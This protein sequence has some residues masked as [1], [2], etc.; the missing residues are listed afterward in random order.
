VAAAV[1]RRREAVTALRLAEGAARH[2]A[3]VLSNGATPAQAVQT[4]REAAAQLDLAVASLA[5]LTR[6]GSLA[7]RKLLVTRLAAMGWT[8][9]QIARHAG[10]SERTVHRVLRPR[11]PAGD[12]PPHRSM[13]SIR[14]PVL[15]GVP[16]SSNPPARSA[17]VAGEGHAQGEP[18]TGGNPR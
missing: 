8:R 13:L 9:A 10:L 2:A 15:S 1:A 11:S 16:D 5:R 3:V 4:A 6:P 7:E 12:G 14:P 18:P 17:V